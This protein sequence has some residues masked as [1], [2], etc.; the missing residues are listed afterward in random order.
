MNVVGIDRNFLISSMIRTLDVS[1]TNSNRSLGYN[2][3]VRKIAC[4]GGKYITISCPIMEPPTA[5]RKVGLVVKPM[6][7]TDLFIDR[8]DKALN[9][10]KNTKQVNVMVVSRGVMTLS[11]TCGCV[12]GVVINT[13]S[14]TVKRYKQ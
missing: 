4:N 3:S 13:T 1:D 9:M 5:S 14:N 11:C 6:E 7:K 12:R 8:H 10:S 2:G